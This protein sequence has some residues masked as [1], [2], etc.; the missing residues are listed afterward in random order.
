MSI[1]ARKPIVGPLILLLAFAILYPLCWFY[2]ATRMETQ[3]SLW[4]ENLRARGFAITHGSVSTAGFPGIIQFSINKPNFRSPDGHWV[5]RGNIVHLG[6][7][8]WNWRRY[9]LEF[10]GLQQ[11]KLSYP[12]PKQ[13]IWLTSKSAVAVLRVHSNGRLAEG[14]VTL[15]SISVMDKKKALVLFTEDM[16]FKLTQPETRISK[17]EKTAVSVAVSIDNLLLPAVAQSPLGGRLARIQFVANLKGLLPKDMTHKGLEKWRQAGGSIDTSW[18][19]LVWGAFDLRGRGSFS[20]DESIRPVG[21]MT[22]D[23]RGYSETMDALEDAGIMTGTGA[24]ALKMG[25]SAFAKTSSADGANVLTIPLMMRG[26]YL[27]AGPFQIL[28]LPPLILPSR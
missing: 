13:P 12:T 16:W 14:E 27:H 28:K 19:N 17:V 20:I 4:V 2:A 5:W 9:R 18:F 8:P 10:S 24:A 7:Q 15:R 22:A 23:I 3:F 26:G 1:F 21:S 25:M 6:M 11:I